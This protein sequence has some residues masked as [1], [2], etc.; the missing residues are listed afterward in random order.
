MKKILFILA[1]SITCYA[2]AQKKT[3]VKKDKNGHLIGYV[4]KSAFL[5]KSYSRWF[6]KNYDS[7][8]TEEAV[9]SKI[10]KK[11]NKCKIA[12]FMGVWCGDSRRE[13]PKLYKILEEANFNM[14]N[15]EMIALNRSKRTPDNLQKGYNIIRIPTF[16][17]YKDGKEIGRFVEYSRETLERDILKILTTKTYKHSYQK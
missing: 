7:Y 13:V 1:L 15:L 17:F 14:D 4:K 6:T 9:I 10:R 2:S 3:A 11:I 5:D 12:G 8:K 16:V